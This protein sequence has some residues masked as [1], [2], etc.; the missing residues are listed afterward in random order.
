MAHLF[1]CDI[2]GTEI[3]KRKAAHLNFKNVRDVCREC[4]TGIEI[5]IILMRRGP[6]LKTLQEYYFN[7]VKN[8]FEQGSINGN[9]G[10]KN[11]TG[12]NQ[13]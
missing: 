1:K 10:R 7:I 5:T 3:D 6:F 12:D 4:I 9:I 13:D 2:C 8:R 11:R